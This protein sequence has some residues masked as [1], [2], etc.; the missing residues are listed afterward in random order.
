MR[1]KIV[2]RVLSLAGCILA[3]GLFALTSDALTATKQEAPTVGSVEEPNTA[4]DQVAPAVM[5]V[6]DPTLEVD[7]VLTGDFSSLSQQCIACPAPFGFCATRPPNTPCGG[8]PCGGRCSTCGGNFE[9]FKCP[10]PPCF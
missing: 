9:C 10:S 6:D 1:H 4:A 3:I 8:M 2:W 5:L 7:L